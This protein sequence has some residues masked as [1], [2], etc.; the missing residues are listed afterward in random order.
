MKVKNDDDRPLVIFILGPTAS[1]KT[2][3]AS[4]LHEAGEG[5][6]ISVD[7]AMVYRG[8][9]IGTAKPTV[10][11]LQRVPHRL[12]DIRDPIEGYST[13][14]FRRDACHEIDDILQ[15][16]RTPLLV[17][18]T[19]L[20]FKTLLEGNTN[21]PATSPEVRH[22]LQTRLE[23]E[24]L[25]A[26]HAELLRIDPLSGARIHPNDPQRT[27]RALEVY[28]QTGRTLT[29]LWQEQQQT[30]LPW[31][32]VTLALAPEERSVLHQRIATRFDD[33]L[34]QGFIEEVTALRSR[35][36]LTADMPS[37]RSVGYRQAWA[38]LEGQD[39]F[40][41]FREK[42]IA[43]TR[44]LAKRQITWLRSWKSPL[45]WCDMTAPNAVSHLLKT[46]RDAHR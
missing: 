19:M 3:A 35:G 17:G 46:V 5:D 18:G 26:L 22:L 8:M 33:M 25:A 29:E 34:N 4:A 36:D 1:G 7:S 6:V 24:G 23:Q 39:D 12:I 31:R 14:E 2:A 38:Y 15:A 30:P 44:Q 40:A 9:N 16:G 37:M 21:L 28:H 20:Y 43:A 41:T 27:L 10:E 11:E 45:T 42:A 13:G 32:V